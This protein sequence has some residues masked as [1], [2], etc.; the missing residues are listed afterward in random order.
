[1][2]NSETDILSESARSYLRVRTQVEI[3]YSQSVVA[4]IFPVIFSLIIGKVV[5]DIANRTFLIA[6]VV[7]VALFCVGRYLLLWSYIKI[8]RKK[9]DYHKWLTRINVAV[10]LSGAM[11]GIPGIILIPYHADALIDFTLYNSLIMLT[12]CGIVAG[13]VISYSINLGTVFLYICPALFPPAVYLITLGDKYNSA[14]G[15]FIMLY[16]IFISLTAYKLNRQLLAYAFK[17]Y[18]YQN[19]KTHYVRLKQKYEDL[20]KRIQQRQ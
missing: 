18:Q 9:I 2:D 3:L 11:W 8:D 19:I 12:V 14:L 16:F 15:G 7:V 20:I 17:E 4:F 6:W 1:M 10:F 13:S 5:W